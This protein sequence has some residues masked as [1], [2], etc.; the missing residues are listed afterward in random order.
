MGT[1]RWR[2]SVLP[3]VRA[4]HNACSKPGRHRS[5]YG[6]HFGHFGGASRTRTRAIVGA[7]TLTRYGIF[8]FSPQLSAS[9]ADGWEN[10]TA[11]GYDEMKPL[12]LKR[13]RVAF[14]LNPQHY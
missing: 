12:V 13:L 10:D 2:R 7:T 3:L 6:L 11:K 8:S 14:A 5:V 1:R 4:A 9:R